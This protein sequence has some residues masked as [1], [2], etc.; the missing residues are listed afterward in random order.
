[1][2]NDTAVRDGVLDWLLRAEM[3]GSIETLFRE[4][5]APIVAQSLR[6]SP[7]A[8]LMAEIT[9]E[10]ARADAAE[11]ALADMTAQRDAAIKHRDTTTKALEIQTAKVKRLSEDCG[12]AVA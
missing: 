1:M 3:T 9:A 6:E 7:L 4:Q 12:K 8:S 11:A 10:K 2:S 5:I